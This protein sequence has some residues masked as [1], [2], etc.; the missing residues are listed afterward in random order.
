M[1]KSNASPIDFS[2]NDY[3]G[4]ARSKILKE[5]VEILLNNNP[6]YFLGSTGSRL[7][8]GNS[9]FCEEL[10]DT[11]AQFHHANSGLLFNSGYDANIG[12][13]SCIAQRGDTIITDE[14]I[15]ASLID[16]AR[17]SYANKYIFKHNDLN[18]LEDK[19]KNSKGN[20]FIVTESVFSMDG[21]LAPLKEIAALAEKYKANLI[22]D[23]AHA[24]GVLGAYGAGLVSHL[25]LE[26]DVFARIH[27]FGKA[28]GIHGAIILGSQELKTYLTNFARS[29]IYTTALPYHTLAGIKVAYENLRKTEAIDKLKENIVYFKENSEKLNHILIS[30]KSAIQCLLIPGNDKCKSVSNHLQSKGFEVKPILSPTVAEGGER[31][32][33]CLHA[34]NTKEEIQNLIFEISKMI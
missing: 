23:E 11:I 18:S 27:T 15:H 31:L 28:I 2:S 33:I 1:L 32:R 12:L 22:V 26:N 7:L 14:L 21:D 16:G 4:F 17:L 10:E 34:Y 6:N 19:L 5:E 3:L 29:F 24:T 20:I 30:S 13:L 25:N 8:S 9:K